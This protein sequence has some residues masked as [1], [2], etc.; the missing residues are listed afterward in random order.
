LGVFWKRRVSDEVRTALFRLSRCIVY[1]SI[2]REPFGMVAAEAMCQGTPVIVPDQGGI[3]EVVEVNG[4]RGG[5]RFKSWDSGDLAEQMA[6][7]ITD[8]ALHAELSGNAK[9]VAA[10]FSVDRMTDRVLELMGLS[11]RQDIQCGLNNSAR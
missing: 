8:D 4:K 2:H 1:P 6:R 7:L 11:E 3:T 9:D 10:S 5:L